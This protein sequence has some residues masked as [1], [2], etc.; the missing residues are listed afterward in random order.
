MT[1][2]QDSYQILIY[3]VHW[4]LIVINTQISPAAIPSSWLMFD[5]TQ[6]PNALL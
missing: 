6:L 2:Q 1:G 5:F 4:R 3:L